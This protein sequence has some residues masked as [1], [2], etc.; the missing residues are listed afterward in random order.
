MPAA[1]AVP[2]VLGGLQAGT[3]LY[4][5]KKASDASKKA[6]AAQERANNKAFDYQRQEADRMRRMNAPSMEGMGD[7]FA[8]MRSLTT[9]GMRY[10]GA[11][12]SMQMQGRMRPQNMPPMGG[13]GPAPMMESGGYGGPGGNQGVG[14]QYGPMREVGQRMQR[15]GDGAP[16]MR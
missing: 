12:H 15:P 9:P 1:V 16:G 11:Q 3:S 6:T 13:P 14:E 2:L 7:H 10:G 8:T 5:A 4:G